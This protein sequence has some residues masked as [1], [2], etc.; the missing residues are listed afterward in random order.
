MAKQ[1]Q[2]NFLIFMTEQHRGDC[3]GLERHPV[4]LT[5]NMDEIGARGVH[6]TRAYSSCPICVPA[7]RSFLTGMFPASHGALSNTEDEWDFPTLPGELRKAGYHT[8]WVGRSPHQS[9]PRKRYG[10]DQMVLDEFRLP[11]DE[12]KEFLARNQPEGAGGYYGSGI[13]H[14]DWTARP[15]TMDNNLHET[16]WTVTEA[17]AF[18]R[19]RDPSAPFCLVVSFLASHPPLIPPAFYMERYLR[20][21]VPDPVIGDWAR[22]PV[23][24][25]LGNGVAPQ[26]QQVNLTGEALLSARAAY[27]GLINHV[28]DEIHRLL[29]P[30]DGIGWETLNNTVIMLCSDHGEML[31]DHYLFWKGKP[32]D[33]ACRV[34]LLVRAPERFGLDMGS[35]VAQPVGL[36][37]IMPTALEMAGVEIPDTVEGRS[38]LPL[39]RGEPAPWRPWIHI[40]FSPLFHCLT[41]GRE[42]YAWFVPDGREQFFDLTSDPKECHDLIADPA[43]AERIGWWRGQLIEELKGRPEGFTD[44]RRLIPGRP[45]PP[46]LLRV[47]D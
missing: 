37:D 19:K 27:Y 23:N 20:T 41:D 26:N 22:R 39:M 13:K 3:L 1:D 43:R 18:L 31:G 36:E 40:E 14:N 24:D 11:D 25:A 29:N 9:P 46:L 6:F 44:G 42:K 8:G 15:W 28:D 45:Y 10:F 4:L 7:R 33:P 12:Y 17:L 35:Q 30:V 5:P 47:S 32:Y 16:H 21:G 38:L 2:P 34:P